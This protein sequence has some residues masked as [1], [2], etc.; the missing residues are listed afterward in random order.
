MSALIIAVVLLILLALV[1]LVGVARRRDTGSA[2][3]ELSRETIS[4]DRPTTE[5]MAGAKPDVVTGKDVERAA[6]L[7]RSG[8][9]AT[10]EK[11]ATGPPPAPWTRPDPDTVGVTRRQ[12]FNRSIIIL[13]ALGLSSFGA[14]IIAFLWPQVSGGFG[15]KIRVGS[16]S[17]I[18]AQIAAG[19]GFLYVPEGRAW[20]TEYPAGALAKAK[21]VY[22]D[23]VLGGME[24]GVVALYQ[25]CPHLGC[26]VPNC[27]TSQWFECPCHGSQFNQAGEKKGGPAPRGMDLFATE[28]SGGALVV[29]TGLVIPGAPIGTNTTGQEAEGPHCVTGGGGH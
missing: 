8:G 25:K 18:K 11:V 14:A 1:L 9:T 27:A 24:E 20:I 7:E 19:G 26:R 23:S 3:G 6:A 22:P 12:F 28:V 2:L 17:D 21:A 4:R 10:L 15:S 13:F 5:A 29:N 16:I